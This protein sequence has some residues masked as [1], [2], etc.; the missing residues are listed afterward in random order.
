M[1]KLNEGT[2]TVNVETPE[3]TATRRSDWRNNHLAIQKA[4][5]EFTRQH[6]RFPAYREIVKLTGFELK[7]VYTHM[8]EMDLNM[9]HNDLKQMLCMFSDQVALALLNAGLRGNIGALKVLFKIIFNYD[10]DAPIVPKH[11]NTTNVTQSREL[12]DAEIETT[13]E[14]LQHLLVLA[15]QRADR[16]KEIAQAQ[17]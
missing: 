3:L 11:S 6:Q 8:Q 14:T 2:N 1:S 12:D 15:Q 13:E 4:I 16:N 17:T 10:F 5:I 7:T 9:L